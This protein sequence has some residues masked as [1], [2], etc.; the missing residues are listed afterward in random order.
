M[1]GRAAGLVACHRS[2]EM[3]E[4]DSGLSALETG[5]A[6]AADEHRDAE[7]DVR[8]ADGRQLQRI[9]L[10]PDV[11]VTPTIAGIRAGKDEVLERAI[12]YLSTP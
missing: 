9:G 3:L 4:R 11:K 2:P 7:Y 6:G 10:V 8:H 12:Q 1:F 5:N